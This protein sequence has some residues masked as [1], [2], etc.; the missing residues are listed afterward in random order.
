MEESI[1]LFLTED[2]DGWRRPSTEHAGEEEKET[3]VWEEAKLNRTGL[4]KAGVV[5]SIYGIGWP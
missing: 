4:Q 2:L 3:P 5:A 1:G